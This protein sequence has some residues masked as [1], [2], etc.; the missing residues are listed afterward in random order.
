MLRTD[1]IRRTVTA[2]NGRRS[3]GRGEAWLTCHSGASCLGVV[4]PARHAGPTTYPGE[5]A[6]PGRRLMRVPLR[7]PVP[8]LADHF[9]IGADAPRTLCTRRRLM[10][11]AATPSGSP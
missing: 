9:T 8:L 11:Q 5:S 1:R 3:I 2:L 4:G 10:S 6:A 7:T